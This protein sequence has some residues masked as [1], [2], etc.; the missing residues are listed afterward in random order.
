MV[1]PVISKIWL[2]VLTEFAGREALGFVMT[3]SISVRLLVG[4][5]RCVNADGADIGRGALKMN[6]RFGA[7]NRG[8][9]PLVSGG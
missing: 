8:S 5:R 7:R 4:G 3:T 6:R 1:Q 9:G 2:V